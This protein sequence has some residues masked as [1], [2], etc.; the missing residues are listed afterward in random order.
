[1]LQDEDGESVY[2]NRPVSSELLHY[3]TVVFPSR[4]GS[5]IR[6][7]SSLTANYAAVHHGSEHQT[8][9]ETEEAAIEEVQ[10]EKV[11]DMD[12]V[13]MQNSAEEEVMYGNITQMIKSKE[14]KERDSEQLK[15][16][17]KAEDLYSQVKPRK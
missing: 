2:A 5:E 6:G 3:S 16:A 11:M 9:G 1:M 4:A 7:L 13:M 15:H 17:E 12:C 14:G 8:E 10:E